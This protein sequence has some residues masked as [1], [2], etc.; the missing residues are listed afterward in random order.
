[1]NKVMSQKEAIEFSKFVC[2]LSPLD[3]DSEFLDQGQWE[4]VGCIYNEEMTWTN[5]S[6]QRV[7]LIVENLKKLCSQLEIEFKEVK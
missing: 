3:F 1:M 2:N 4:T 6:P 5:P 7:D